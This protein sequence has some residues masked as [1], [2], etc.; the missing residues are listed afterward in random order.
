M[1]H[2]HGLGGMA[3]HYLASTQGQQ[4]IR[5]Y[6]ATEEGQ[7]TFDEFLA[8]PHGQQTALMLLAKALDG[9]D[10]PVE[11]KEIIRKAMADKE[12]KGHSC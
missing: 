10:L 6:L 3:A 4:T 1:S 7:K 8:T 2:L 5:N 9:L 12:R 11:T